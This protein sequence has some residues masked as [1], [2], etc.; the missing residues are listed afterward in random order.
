MQKFDTSCS[1]IVF[2]SNAP[3][4]TPQCDLYKEYLY[5]GEVDFEHYFKG[6][7]INNQG[8]VFN[9]KSFVMT[10]RNFKRLWYATKKYS[11][12][13]YAKDV[14]CR[15]NVDLLVYWAE[16]KEVYSIIPKEN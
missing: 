12:L 3:F 14:S 1:C 8:T 11:F 5:V 7:Y 6:S 13:K 4:Y 15:H 10:I 16:T 2:P 9:E